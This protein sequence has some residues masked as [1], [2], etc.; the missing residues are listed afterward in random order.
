MDYAVL[1]DH[2]VKFEENEKKDKYLDFARQWKK[3]WSMKVTFISVVIGAV[4]IVTEILLKG[5]E[6]LEIR[7]RVET[8]QTTTL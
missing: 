4:G 5:L 8:I 6:N 3:L 1:V 2:R 7:G